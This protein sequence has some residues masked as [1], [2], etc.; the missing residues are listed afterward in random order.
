MEKKLASKIAVANVDIVEADKEVVWA[1]PKGCVWFT[2][3]CRTNI[4]IRI[5]FAPKK[6]QDSEM[7][8]GTLKSGAS[9][10]ENDFHIEVKEGQQV[11][12]AAASAVVIEIFMGIHTEEET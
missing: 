2:M 5:G 10:D 12:F 3:Q 7:P 11:F 8:Y 6:A 9:W 1:I 4:S